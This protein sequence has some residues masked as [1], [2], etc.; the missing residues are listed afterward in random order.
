MQGHQATL[1]SISLSLCLDWSLR[2]FPGSE[3]S[4]FTWVAFGEWFIAKL[5]PSWG[6]YK[7]IMLC[8]LSWYHSSMASVVDDL[9]YHLCSWFGGVVVLHLFWLLLLYLELHWLFGC[10]ICCGGF[11]LLVVVKLWPYVIVVAKDNTIV[12][13][14]FGYTCS[15][16]FLSSSSRNVIL[17]S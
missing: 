14:G 1:S 5:V 4:Y 10:L 8:L 7:S 16:S 17:W 15:H 9:W 6:D 12:A 3:C 11:A 2:P 13:N